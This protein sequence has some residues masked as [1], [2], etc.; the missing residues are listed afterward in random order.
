MEIEMPYLGTI[1]DFS[2]I[3]ICGSIGYLVKDII[4]KRITNAIVLAMSV[5]AIY[6]GIEGA[7][8]PVP[9]EVEGEFL[10]AS[11]MKM[12]VMIIS[13]ALG[14]FI[15]ELID[16]EKW[17][18]RF[19]LFIERKLTK[20]PAQEG[21]FAR[22][23]VTCTLLFCVGAMAVNGAI[24][25]AAGDPDLL[26]AKAL[27][28]G[29]MCLVLTTTLGIGCIFSAFP[30][31]IYEGLLTLFAS[32]IFANLPPEMLGYMSATGSLIIFFIGT[33]Q[34]GVTKL[35]TANMVPAIFLP[36]AVAPLLN[37]IA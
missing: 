28:D 16:I 19:G 2:A 30:I 23:F 21:G 26:F 3:L 31:L 13:L 37:L 20:K 6:I 7:L 25:D 36:L 12:L 22:G 14:T 32:L 24:Q 11:L 34:L 9:L 33:N 15:G 17:I 10:D 35:R 5:F 4:P 27:I 1:V 18:E 29:I 8:E